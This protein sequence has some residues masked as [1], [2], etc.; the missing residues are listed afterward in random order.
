MFFEWIE[1]FNILEFSKEKL[2]SYTDF[3]Y[4]NLNVISFLK[5]S[6]MESA[7]KIWILG[8]WKLDRKLVGSF[9]RSHSGVAQLFL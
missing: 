1:L 8:A 2:V 6:K 7:V 3:E 5:Y 9:W 4:S